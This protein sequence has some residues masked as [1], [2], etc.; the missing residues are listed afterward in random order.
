[1]T[2]KH[3][4]VERL[5]QALED[6]A[7]SGGGNLFDEQEEE[8]KA[9]VRKRALGLLDQRARSRTEL[10]GRLIALEFDA[11]L[12]ESVLDDLQNVGLIDDQAFADTW[13]RQRHERRGKSALVLDRE[14]QEKGVAEHIR[15]QALS[16]VSEQDEEAAARAAAAKKTRTISSVPEDRQDYDRQLRRVVGVL[17]RRGY[18]AGV[19]MRIAKEELALRIEELGGGD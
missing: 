14:L 18:G 17:A 2:S 12:V 7:A 8:A 15:V 3:E 6:Y 5:R 16:Q 1:M 9:A 4:K 11:T 10:S 19:S 13:V